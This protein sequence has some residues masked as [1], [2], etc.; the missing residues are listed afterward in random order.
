[1]KIKKNDTVIVLS[2]KD[3][4]KKGLVIKAI[5]KE[6]KVIVQ[7]V[8]VLKKIVKARVRGEKS[9]VVEKPYPIAVCKVAKAE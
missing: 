2:G 1:M 4:G 7:G 3:K 6:D 9:T 5:P 8:H